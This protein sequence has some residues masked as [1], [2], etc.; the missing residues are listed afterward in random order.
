MPQT[1]SEWF[2]E[3]IQNLQGNQS[4]TNRRNYNHRLKLFLEMHGEER[5]ADISAMDVNAWLDILQSRGLAEAT[6]TG[7][8][9]ALKAFFNF[10]VKQGAIT[11][12]PAAH[13]AT[14]SFSSKRRKVPAESDVER[15]TK[16][17]FEWIYSNKKKQIRDGL[18]FLLA[19]GSG[20]R[21]R[22]IR[23]LRKS[24]VEAALHAGPDGYGVYQVSSIGK[25]KD[26]YLRFDG[27][28]ARG[29]ERW[30]QVR[31]GKARIDRCFVTYFPTR[32]ADDPVRR[33]RPL[34]R[35]TIDSVFVRISKAA[36]L[37][38]PIRSQALR[39]RLG[40]LTTRKY[41]A[42]VAALVLNHKDWQSAATALTFY[43]HP[44]E[45]DISQAIAE[46][47][48]GRAQDEIYRLFGVEK[49]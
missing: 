9:Q 12:S 7:Y 47:G 22:E 18:I 19:K 13:V 1:L 36:G 16:V 38:R 37:E 33:F 40:D 14:G 48:E 20:P 43:H 6:M 11:R 32:T 34:T 44:E 25:T 46:Q 41:G 31:P 5:P 21:Q 4:A 15:V 45:A 39:H 23:E 49:G 26:V 2:N 42:K 8:R 24:E 29:F 17:A 35:S 30:L 3:F 10:C 28:V 27:A